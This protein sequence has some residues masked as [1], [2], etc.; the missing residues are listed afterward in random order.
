M[1]DEPKYG[2]V[3][4]LGLVTSIPLLILVSIGI[5]LLV[6]RWLDGKFGSSPWITIIL[7]LIG[8]AAGLYESAKLLIDVTKNE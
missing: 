7:T 8:L 4:S 2:W 1:S 5:G 3:R 6:G